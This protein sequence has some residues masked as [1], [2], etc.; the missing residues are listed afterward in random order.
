[1]GKIATYKHK[2]VYINTLLSARNNNS[3]MKDGEKNIDAREKKRQ[4]RRLNIRLALKHDNH[5]SGKRKLK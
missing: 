1:M 5:V 3:K 4:P 2:T